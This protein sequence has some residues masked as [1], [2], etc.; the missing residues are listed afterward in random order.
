MQNVK[1]TRRL[2]PNREENDNKQLTKGDVMNPTSRTNLNRIQVQHE[3]RRQTTNNQNSAKSDVWP[4][5][6]RII[7]VKEEKYYE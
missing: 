6:K 4:S 2:V 5:D 1:A 7:L 3:S